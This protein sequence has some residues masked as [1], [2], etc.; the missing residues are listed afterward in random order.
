MDMTLFR[1][2]FF[3]LGE[4]SKSIHALLQSRQVYLHAN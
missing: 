4:V 1:V 2:S 3:G